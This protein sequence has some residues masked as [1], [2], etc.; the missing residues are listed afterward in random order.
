MSKLYEI[1]GRF[2]QDGK[3]SEPDPSFKG[4]IIVDDNKEFIG[5]CDELYDS[6]QPEV[7][8]KRYLVGAFAPNARNG[9]E[10][11]AFY[12]FSNYKMQ[13][14]LMYVVPDMKDPKNGAWSTLS[15]MLGMFLPVGQAEVVINEIEY[16]KTTE[17]EIREQYGQLDEEDV[18]TA[19]LLEQT[20]CLKDI[21]KN[22]E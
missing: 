6:D 12:K 17:A 2:Y 9:N 7:S 10:G 3:W 8:K 18:I 1:T 4:K 11:I 5:Y 13:T 14:P 16:D 22:S 15:L 21:L 20:Y 19:A